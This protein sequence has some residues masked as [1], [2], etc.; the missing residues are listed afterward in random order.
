M[1]MDAR[2]SAASVVKT[3]GPQSADGE[4]DGDVSDDP[5][6]RQ[7]RG[8]EAEVGGDAKGHGGVIEDA[9][10]GERDQFRERKFAFAALAS[11]ALVGDSDLLKAQR[12]N[13]SAEV[14][15]HVVETA[16]NF[17]DATANQPEVS[18]IDGNLVFAELVDEAIEGAAG[19]VNGP[20]LFAFD[21]HP[22]DYVGS[23]P[24]MAQE[25][26]DEFRRILQIAVELDS[27]G[28]TG[29]DV[30]GH[31]GA[32]IAEVAGEAVDANARIADCKRPEA[33][34]SGVGAVI[35]CEDELEAVVLGQGFGDG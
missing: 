19:Q 8:C 11:G 34:E 17:D 28:A 9:V 22:V 30:A 10:E 32:L 14:W 16:Q 26:R 33:G 24:P 12:C 29:L 13:G 18:R 20:P 1:L 31:D 3:G 23:F 35:V 21:P 4:L 27:S 25:G 7:Y 2:M 5:Q 6:Q 15:V